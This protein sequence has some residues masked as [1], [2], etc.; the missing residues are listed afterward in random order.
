M[1]YCKMWLNLQVL[2]PVKRL[3]NAECMSMMIISAQ[4]VNWRDSC[5]I[6]ELQILTLSIR[7][8]QSPTLLEGS[9]RITITAAHQSVPCG[10]SGSQTGGKTAVKKLHLR[11]KKVELPL[12][13]RNLILT[14]RLEAKKTS[15]Y[16]C[17]LIY[18]MIG[19]L[20]WRPLRFVGF[21]T[22]GNLLD[23]SELLSRTYFCAQ[24]R[25]F[26]LEKGLT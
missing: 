13:L 26:N 4:L 8:C 15:A 1:S 23:R 16:I 7:S 11:G 25:L 19:M 6:L 10:T 14:S 17:T 9:Q 18:D 2:G 5:G 24:Q 21:G 20:H 3:N 12:L 22:F